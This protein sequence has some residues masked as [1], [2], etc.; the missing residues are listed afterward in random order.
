MRPGSGQRRRELLQPLAGVRIV[1]V[2]LTGGFA[3]LTPG[4]I[5]FRPAQAEYV[6]V[7]MESCT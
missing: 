5:S 1:V 2:L 7:F 4:L 3:S 6:A